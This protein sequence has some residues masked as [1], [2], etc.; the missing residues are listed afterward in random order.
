MK[1]IEIGFKGSGGCASKGWD[2]NG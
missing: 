1:E 2:E